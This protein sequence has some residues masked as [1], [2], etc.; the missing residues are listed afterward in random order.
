VRHVRKWYRERFLHLLK[1]RGSGLQVLS[2]EDIAVPGGG[3]AAPFSSLPSLTRLSLRFACD[4]ATLWAVGK[5]CPSLQ[6]LD[7]EGSL[8]VTDLGV[9]SLCLRGLPQPQHG[10][11]VAHPEGAEPI[12][13]LDRL[14]CCRARTAAGVGEAVV[15]VSWLRASLM[16]RS[17]KNA[18]CA[19]LTLINLAST[20]VTVIGGVACIKSSCPS[21]KVVILRDA[22]GSA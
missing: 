8:K 2:L 18:C 7:V 3:L 5:G 20:S 17:R 14:W 12:S 10:G 21:T 9:R 6:E 15:G 13:L 1:S 22:L 4:D 11:G 16:R 19:T